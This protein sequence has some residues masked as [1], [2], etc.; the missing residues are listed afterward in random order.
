MLGPQEH[1]W[2]GDPAQS[3]NA[4]L[5]LYIYIYIYIYL[6]LHL[7]INHC[8]IIHAN[9]CYLQ[10]KYISHRNMGE[11]EIWWH[12][13]CLCNIAYNQNTTEKWTKGFI[14]PFPKKTT[15]E[16]QR[17]TE[18]YLLQLLLLMII[19]SGFSIS[20]ELK[21]TK[22]LGKI[23]TSF[24]EIDKQ[25]FRFWLIVESLKEYGQNISKQHSCFLDFSKKF[26]FG[27]SGKMEQ[28]F[29]HMVSQRNFYHYYDA[30]HQTWKLFCSLIPLAVLL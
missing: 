9:C 1:H 18:A 8:F 6:C 21:L 30:I 7:F 5:Q 13:F 3:L 26:D 19:M 16:S 17:T 11:K 14:L 24:G 22:I 12:I 27:H 23:R 20:S 29:Q 10:L 15:S 2:R 28:I 25:H 4:C